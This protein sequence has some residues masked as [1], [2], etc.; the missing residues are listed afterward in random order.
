MSFDIN[1][2]PDNTF[3]PSSNSFS[4]I[5]YI[6][7]MTSHMIELLLT[8]MIWLRLIAYYRHFWTFTDDCDTTLDVEKNH[9]KLSVL[10]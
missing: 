7:T 4:S 10:V 6:I 1:H 8:E 5:L 2:T 9:V 3:L